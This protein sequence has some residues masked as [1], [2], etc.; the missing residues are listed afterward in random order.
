M[1]QRGGAEAGFLIRVTGRLTCR[2]KD[3]V[4]GGLHSD[5]VLTG[6]HG[7]GVLTGLRNDVVLTGR[8]NDCGLIGLT[9][10]ASSPVS[11]TAASSPAS[12]HPPPHRLPR[13]VR[14]GHPRHYTRPPP[15]G[16]WAAGKKQKGR[17]G[18]KGETRQKAA[19]NRQNP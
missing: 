11:T 17:T 9:A 14:G 1:A 12:S 13:P 7:D 6:L 15:E 8:C 18:S 3:G 16:G 5:G 4:L 2:R 19:G 10:T